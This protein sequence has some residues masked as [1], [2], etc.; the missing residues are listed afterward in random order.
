MSEYQY[1]AFRAIDSPVSKKNLDYMHKQSSRAE[2]TPWRFTNEYHYGD[3]RGNALEMLRRGYDLHLHYAN[4]GTR[5]LLI[6]L[7]HGFPDPE[8]VGPYLGKSALR[9]VKDRTGVGGTLAIEPY[10]EPGDL[11]ELWDLEPL[12]DRLAPLRAEILASDLRPLYLAH[13]AVSGDYEHDPDE[14]TEGPVPAGLGTLTDAQR[15]LAELYEIDVSLLAAAAQES[16]PLPPQESQRA[17]YA[18]WLASQPEVDKNRWL[19]ELMNEPNSTVRAEILAEFHR[20]QLT[21]PWPTVR[22]DRT[23]SQLQAA[24]ERWQ[25]AA[26]QKAAAREQRQ[27]LKKL[28]GIA[29]D[30]QPFLQQAEELVGKR[31]TAAY[32]EAAELLAE[33]R[34]ALAGKSQSNLAER[35]AEKLKANHPTLRTLTSA[36]RR[37]G[38]LLK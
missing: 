12:I 7:P 28:A 27:R 23:L 31:T 33:V 1:V 6:R 37:E 35:H 13:L 38:F 15:A 5:S 3:F 32:R 30:P 18:E 34:E 16:P 21:R 26:D 36:L 17:Q 8:S 4:F 22:R 20:S 2:I 14:T 11:E 29:A 25:H 19:I 9:Y 24:A 10:F